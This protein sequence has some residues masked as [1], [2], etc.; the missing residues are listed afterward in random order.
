MTGVGGESREEILA[1]IE[2]LRAR[3]DLFVLYR[4]DPGRACRESPPHG[5]LVCGLHRENAVRRIGELEAEI[6]REIERLG[7]RVLATPDT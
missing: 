7:L 6:Q 5:Y 1:R 4:D 3:R 2:A